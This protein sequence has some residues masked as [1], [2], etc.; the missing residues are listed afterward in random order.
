[1][2]DASIALLLEKC[3]ERDSRA[4]NE[5]YRLYARAMHNVAF[6]IVKDAHYAED[7]TQEAFLKAFAKLGDYRKDVA[8]GAWLKRIVINQSID[9]YKKSA[10]IRTEDFDTARQPVETEPYSTEAEDFKKTQLAQLMLAL[11]QL[12]PAYR[13]ILNLHFLEG[14]DYEEMTEILNISYQNCRT[15]LSRAKE[16]LRKKLKEL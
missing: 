8:F 13:I 6:R 7:I 12:K 15:T 14:Y 2:T 3:L 9:F 1:M 4:Q 10:K 11:D 16:S 5:I